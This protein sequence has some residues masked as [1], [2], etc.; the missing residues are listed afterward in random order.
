M[1]FVLWEIER[2]DRIKMIDR[3]D[4]IEINFVFLKIYKL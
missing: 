2:I 1:I 4:R 3:I